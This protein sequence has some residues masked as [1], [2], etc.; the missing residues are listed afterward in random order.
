MLK[1][2]ITT[3][4]CIALFSTGAVAQF[5]CPSAEELKSWVDADMEDF[6]EMSQSET[7][8]VMGWFLDSH[9]HE[10]RWT[11]N[12]RFSWAFAILSDES[13]LLYCGYNTYDKSY[14]DNIDQF[15][16][17][18]DAMLIDNGL[19]LDGV[20]SALIRSKLTRHEYYKLWNS[21]DGVEM[22]E[23]KSPNHSTYECIVEGITY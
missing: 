10:E 5:S 13:V 4:T 8:R 23:C 14:A 9:L 1:I 6:A 7:D 15:K 11:Y 17:G 20:T 22:Y 12:F 19:T 18:K 21:E 16:G 3:I 2:I